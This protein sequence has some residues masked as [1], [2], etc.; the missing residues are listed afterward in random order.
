M[1]NVGLWIQIT[2]EKLMIKN[3]QSTST[4]LKKG[5]PDFFINFLN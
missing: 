5:M 4:F 1:V 3:N 2:S